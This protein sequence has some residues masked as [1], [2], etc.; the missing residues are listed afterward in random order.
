[1]K[2]KNI[3]DGERENFA[4][5][6]RRGFLRQ[7]CTL[8]MIGGGV[9]LIGRP[10]AVDIP[11]TKGLLEQYA[12]WLARE[13]EHTVLELAQS[14]PGS[15]AALIQRRREF[16]ECLP[17]WGL[18]GEERPGPWPST[19]AAVVLSAAGVPISGGRNV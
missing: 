18:R 9:T 7:L 1:L 2:E 5:N 17:L 11:V 15:S 3:M 10:T 19:R 16:V 12:A 6:S 4:Q 13:H 14:I 8:P